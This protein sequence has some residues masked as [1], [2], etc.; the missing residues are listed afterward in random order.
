MAFDVYVATKMIPSVTQTR[1]MMLRCYMMKLVC[2]WRRLRVIGYEPCRRCYGW[3]HYF[4]RC[5]YVQYDANHV[6]RMIRS[7]SEYNASDMLLRGYRHNMRDVVPLT[8]N[9]P[10]RH[11]TTIC[12]RDEV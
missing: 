12:R 4:C 1:D 9:K 5:Y 7:S 11:A 3:L 2:C 8:I 10:L 6:L